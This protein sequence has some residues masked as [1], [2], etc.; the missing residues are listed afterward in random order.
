MPLRIATYA[1]D[2]RSANRFLVATRTWTCRCRHSLVIF[3]TRELRQYIPVAIV[4]ARAR[5]AAIALELYMPM[6]PHGAHYSP[7]VH[8]PAGIAY[9]LRDEHG[10]D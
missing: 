4:D 7:G 8:V 6:P 10:G 1:R 2:L 9:G 5:A 3:H